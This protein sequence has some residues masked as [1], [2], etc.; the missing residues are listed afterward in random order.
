MARIPRMARANDVVE[1]LLQEYA[2]LLSIS[3]GDPFRVR[4]YEKAA[5]SVG[6]YHTDI[7]TIDLKGF[8]AIPNVGKSIAEKIQEYFERGS[9]NALE[10]LRAQVPAG[11][12]RM[13][14]I[15]G[16]GPKKAMGLYRD[17]RIASIDE[18]ADAIHDG[19]LKGLK[20]FGDKTEENIL[21]GIELMQQSG[22]RVLISMATDLA[23]E[24]V[25]E[26]KAVRGCGK[27]A[28]AGSLRRM[29]ETIGDIDI[30]VA[31]RKPG[32]VMDAFAGLS[33]V[34]R[35]IARGDTKT[36]IRTTKGLQVDLRVVPP[37]CWG[38]AL[39]YFTGSKAHNIRTREIAVRKGLKLS[40]YGLFEAKSGELIVAETEEEV[41]ERLGLPWIPPTLRE[42]RG[43]IEAAQHGELPTLVELKDLKGDLHTHTNLTDGL[44]TVEEMLETAA[45][46]K[47]AYYAITDHAPNLYMQEMTDEKMPAQRE[48]VRKLQDAYP[49]MTLL[50]GSE[51]NIDP[52]GD[53]DWGPEFLERF[54][55][56]VASVH[57]HFNQ[58]KDDMTKRIVRACENPY[59]N[60]IGHPTARLI[61]RR[62]PIE[63]DLDEVFKA[64]ARTGTALEINSYPDRLDLKDEHILWARRHGVKFAIDT[65]SHS[66]LHL[67]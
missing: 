66:T 12:R 10:E 42:D 62:A 36:S 33:Y 7:A 49:K 4:T 35:V 56:C 29:A 43:E 15:P 13:I 6:G 54:D 53:V 59:V 3:G 18:L 20:G 21:R 32:P 57:S 14:S 5:R 58:A 60:V 1:A 41:Y 17:L 61:G 67:G 50:H 25:G 8:Q 27:C 46:M 51:L 55:I 39:Q 16:L 63:Y 24:I 45:S 23:E 64:A 37:N 34:D 65:D 2:D 9:I 40:E 11:V 31:A 52:T 26:L 48:R 19:R 30:L 28:Y 38:A 22:D 47:Y 44:S